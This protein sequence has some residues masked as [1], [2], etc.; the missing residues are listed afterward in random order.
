MT[1]IVDAN[2]I[3]KLFLEETDSAT[4]RGFLAMVVQHKTP[5]YA[6]ALLAFEVYAIG[7]HHG[8]EVNIPQITMNKLT[9]AVLTLI[10]PNAALW[11]RAYAMAQTGNKKAG[12]PSLQDCLYHALAIETGGVFITA[13]KRHLAKTA[14][15]G[16][17]VHLHDWQGLF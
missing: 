7:I 1:I 8:L 3:G 16:H 13:D 12:Y 15:F 6:P 5:L 4:A 17:A 9:S 11:Q 2:I 14:S 10:E